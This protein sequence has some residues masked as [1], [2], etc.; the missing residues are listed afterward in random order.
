MC[1]GMRARRNFSRG[2]GHQKHLKGGPHI[3]F[4]PTLKYA[5]RGGGG[6]FDSRRVFVGASKSIKVDLQ[7]LQEERHV[8]NNLLY[9]TGE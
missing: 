7:N 8:N 9:T 6:S 5:Y 3:F 2:G 1:T 4:R